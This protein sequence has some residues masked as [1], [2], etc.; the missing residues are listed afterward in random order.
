MGRQIKSKQKQKK[1]RQRKR[2]RFRLESVVLVFTCLLVVFTLTL[3]AWP[4]LADRLESRLEHLAESDAP[5]FLSWLIEREV[6]V[7]EKVTIEAGQ[8]QIT[9]QLFLADPARK[10]AW[11]DAAAVPDGIETGLFSVS[12][13]VDDQI[14][15]SV[16]HVED[17]TAPVVETRDITIWQDETA[18]P[19]DF[20]VSIE[21]HS[22]TTAAFNG[23]PDLTQPGSQTVGLLVTDAAGNQTEAFAQLSINI[24]EEPPV[25]S[26]TKDLA[27]YVG[28]R[29]AYREGVTATDNKDGDITVDIDSSQV[30]LRQEG[31]YPVHYSA[32]DKAGNRSEIT[33][34]VTVKTPV[35]EGV[36]EQALYDLADQILQEITH[37]DMTQ[38]DVARAIYNYTRGHIRYVNESD[39]SNWLQGADQGLR[40]QYGDCFN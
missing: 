18:V 33:I 35:P 40:Q 31:T 2:R 38:T 22:P 5:D 1:I 19:E 36:D 25:I 20:I 7:K 13:R 12:L 4:V 26:G 3:Y 14:Y 34:T 15:T 21:D 28:D 6:P 23:S 24:D 8:V 27:V 39:K 30:N 16:L 37:A 11:Q 32:T 17:T 29:V 9:P 10:A